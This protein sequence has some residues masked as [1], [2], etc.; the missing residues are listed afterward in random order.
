MAGTVFEPTSVLGAGASG[1]SGG[2]SLEGESY[3]ALRQ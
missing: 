1:S 3:A 2:Q